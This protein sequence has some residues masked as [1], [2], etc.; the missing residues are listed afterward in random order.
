M[1]QSQ[2]S[3]NGAAAANKSARLSTPKSPRT[4]NTPHPGK[5]QETPEYTSEDEKL[6]KELD[7]ETEAQASEEA[8]EAQE[9]EEASEAQGDKEITDAEIKKLEADIGASTTDTAQLEMGI[10]VAGRLIKKHTKRLKGLKILVSSAIKSNKKKRSPKPLNNVY[11]NFEGKS[12][13]VNPK[14]KNKLDK[15]TEKI[16]NLNDKKDQYL[17][18]IEAIKILKKPNTPNLLLSILKGKKGG[19]LISISHKNHK[20]LTKKNHE[21]KKH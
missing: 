3:D 15:I 1:E 6:L 7:E 16:T 21:K 19:K 13:R 14:A 20:N 9:G 2:N 17:A 12:M 8:L 18:Q 4:R 5:K 10:S 11:I